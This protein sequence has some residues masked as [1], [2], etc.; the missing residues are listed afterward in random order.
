MCCRTLLLPF[1]ME[2][3]GI[4]IALHRIL[5]PRRIDTNQMHGI[6]SI[7]IILLY[8]EKVIFKSWKL[9]VFY[10]C[11]FGSLE[12]TLTSPSLNSRRNTTSP[13]THPHTHLYRR[14]K[15]LNKLQRPQAADIRIRP[16]R[17]PPQPL[18]DI[19]LRFDQ[20]LCVAESIHRRR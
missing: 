12:V 18:L 11:L 5:S 13:L 8:I 6:Y 4:K 3:T 15:S 20:D 10:S 2:D 19:G 7:F 9:R 17:R 1:L 14:P 16:I